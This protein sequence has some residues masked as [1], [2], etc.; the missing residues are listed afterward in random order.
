MVSELP[1]SERHAGADAIPLI[2][3][4]PPVSKLCWPTPRGEVLS[5][6]AVTE[7]IETLKARLFDRKPFQP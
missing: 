2:E 3:T 6:H 1:Y 7:R 5:R 4:A